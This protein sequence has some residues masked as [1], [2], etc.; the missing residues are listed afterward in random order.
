MK[1]KTMCA[2]V[3]WMRVAEKHTHTHTQSARLTTRKGQKLTC[4]LKNREWMK[5]KKIARVSDI[6]FYF[7]FLLYFFYSFTNNTRYL[8]YIYICAFCT[9][10][11]SVNIGNGSIHRAMKTNAAWLWSV[12]RV[13]VAFVRPDTLHRA[14][15]FCLVLYLFILFVFFFVHL[16][17]RLWSIEMTHTHTHA[18]ATTFTPCGHFDRFRMDQQTRFGALNLRRVGAIC[19]HTRKGNILEKS[20]CVHPHSDNDGM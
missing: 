8:Y 19:A 17:F 14:A 1:S 11:V 20:L 5:N 15:L 9:H 6:L 7:F 4:Q 18:H 2:D 12:V 3:E 16:P 10:K 13:V